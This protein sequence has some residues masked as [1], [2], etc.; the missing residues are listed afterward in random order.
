MDLVPKE[1]IFELS[2][3]PG[4]KYT[5]C[6]WSLRVRTWATAKF[7][8][9]GLKEIFEQQKIEE[10]ADMAFFMLKEKEEFKTKDDFLDAISSMQDQYNIILALLGAVGIGEPEMKKIN[11]AAKKEEMEVTPNPLVVRPKKKTGAKSSTP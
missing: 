6:R 9:Q 3:L 7:T 8:S 1:T 2:T 4:K 5:L 11:A 10:I